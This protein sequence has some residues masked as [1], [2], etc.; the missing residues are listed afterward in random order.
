M[1]RGW[2]KYPGAQMWERRM[3]GW[4]KKRLPEKCGRRSSRFRWEK[5]FHLIITK[6]SIYIP[7]LSGRCRFIYSTIREESSQ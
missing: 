7:L 5:S 6:T 4:M 1:E 2:G 3:R